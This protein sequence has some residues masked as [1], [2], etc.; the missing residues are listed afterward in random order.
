MIRVL[1]L[2]FGLMAMASLSACGESCED[3][4]E[5]FEQI[6]REIAEEPETV[7]DRSAELEEIG[8]KMEEN[9]CLDR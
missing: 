9:G 3:L 5:A 8:K 7:L 2:A 6:T 1:F 4:N